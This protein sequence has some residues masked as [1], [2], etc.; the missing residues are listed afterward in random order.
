[1]PAPANAT[2]TSCPSAVLFTLTTVPSPHLAWLTF[3]PAVKVVLLAL[4]S[5]GI[6]LVFGCK[7]QLALVVRFSFWG[8]TC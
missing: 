4:A 3:S 8:A 5:L 7:N 1:M 6:K 2:L